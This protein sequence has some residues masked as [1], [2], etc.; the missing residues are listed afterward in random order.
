MKA[1]PRKSRIDAPGALH[2]VVARGIDRGKIFQDPV[3]KRN[4]IER[5]AEIIKG[6]ET[7]CYAWALIPNH[8]HLLLRTG[9]THYRL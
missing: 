7:S 3:D 2:H 9:K 1:M 8:F 4:F 5:L 6:T